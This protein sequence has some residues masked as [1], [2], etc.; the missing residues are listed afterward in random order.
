MV[1]A[2]IVDDEKKSRE[3]LKR[4]IK[5]SE[6]EVAILAEGG[7]VEEGVQVIN[8]YE[9]QIV[10]LDVE[11]LDGTG[12]N[13]LEQFNK[14]EFK[15]IFITAYDKYA[16]KAFKYSAIDYLLK[17]IDIEELEN[18]VVKAKNSLDIE[19]F[20]DSQIKVLLSNIK[21]E[22]N[23]RIT[24]SSASRMDFLNV[25]EI[26]C[27][28]AQGAYTEVVLSGKR[29][30]VA[31]RPLKYFDSMFHDSTGFYRVSKSHIIALKYVVSYKKNAELIELV[32]G[33]EIELSRRRKKEF[34]SLL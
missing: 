5:E 12:F 24:I 22:E 33:I 23:K 19:M 10:F 8:E 11:M 28:K 4:L 3:V 15:V 34:L 32:D 9:P 7:S 6:L 29:K 20:N 18:S 25:D 27:L 1:T 16:I 17:P 13:L 21:G 2:V 31:S 30:I 14:V 26:V